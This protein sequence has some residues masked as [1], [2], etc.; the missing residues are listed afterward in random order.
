VTAEGERIAR[1]APNRAGA[2]RAALSAARP[3]LDDDGA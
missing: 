2:T 3:A 1:I